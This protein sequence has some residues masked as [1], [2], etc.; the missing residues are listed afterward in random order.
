MEKGQEVVLKGIR[1]EKTNRIRVWCPLCIQY[2]IHSVPMGRKNLS[3]W[4]E[5]GCHK[6][7][8]FNTTGGYLISLYTPVEVFDI[9]A[10]G[11]IH[12]G[13]AGDI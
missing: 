12:H 8:G 10:F 2:H 13:I 9:V 11:K 3:Q 4:A 6:G 7:K 1:E 5:C